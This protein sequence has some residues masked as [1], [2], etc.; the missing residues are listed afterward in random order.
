MP[1]LMLRL[2]LMRISLPKPGVRF[3]PLSG[4][5]FV[6]ESAGRRESEERNDGVET[7]RVDLGA[8]LRQPDEGAEPESE[9]EAATTV[10]PARGFTPSAPLPDSE[11]GDDDGVPTDVIETRSSEEA[12]TRVVKKVE[13]NRGDDGPRSGDGQPRTKRARARTQ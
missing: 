1:R 8:D 11:D 5:R 12:Q 10:L 6:P 2:L 13:K 7:E 4:E 9:E 3:V